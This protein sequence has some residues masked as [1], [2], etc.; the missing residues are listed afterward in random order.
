MSR[1]DRLPVA[2]TPQP[3]REQLL[4]LG[5]GKIKPHHLDRAAYVY[6]RQSSPQQVLNNT[7]SAERQ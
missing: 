5:G 6:V 2:G 3:S 1:T 7:E 4:A